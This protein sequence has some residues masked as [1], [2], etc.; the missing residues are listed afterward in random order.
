M[1]GVL[2]LNPSPIRVTVVGAPFVHIEPPETG[3]GKHSLIRIILRSQAF[4]HVLKVPLIGA[5]Y[6]IRFTYVI[7]VTVTKHGVDVAALPT[8]T[9]PKYTP[10]WVSG[11]HE[12]GHLMAVQACIDDHV[13]NGAFL[14]LGIS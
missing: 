14:N 2:R 9:Y 3:V 10:W 11:T 6:R 13:F 1:K 8:R 7:D 12:K 5:P 4:R